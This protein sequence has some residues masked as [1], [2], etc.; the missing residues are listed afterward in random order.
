MT[1][2]TTRP[3]GLEVHGI[4]AAHQ[5]HWNLAPAVLYEHAL[6]RAE[7][8]IAA[9]GPLVCRT[10]QHTGRSPNDKFIVKDATSD[11]HVHWGKVN[12]PMTAEHFAALDKYGPSPIH[13]RSFEP[14]RVAAAGIQI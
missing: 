14:V 4:T 3:S 11:P 8:V 12:R 13:R 7:G 9:E 10:G 2:S 1:S 6:R 5:V